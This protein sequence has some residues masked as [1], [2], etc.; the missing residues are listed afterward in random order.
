MTHAGAEARFF[1]DS[2]VRGIGWRRTP[3]G[4]DARQGSA[5]ER[6]EISYAV[7][8][9]LQWHGERPDHPRSGVARH[10]SQRIGSRRQRQGSPQGQPGCRELPVGFGEHLQFDGVERRV[11][12]VSLG[13]AL[14]HQ[15]VDAPS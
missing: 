9:P 12:L 7:L 11:D 15:Q 5:P 14:D 10:D 3:G 6:I 8:Q 1:A 13:I 2:G 4:S